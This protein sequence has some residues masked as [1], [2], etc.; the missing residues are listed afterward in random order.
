MKEQI[1]ESL[2]SPIHDQYDSRLEELVQKHTQQLDELFK[3]VDALKTAANQ[4]AKPELPNED[5]NQLSEKEKEKNDF[6][7]ANEEPNINIMLDQ[8]LNKRFKKQDAT[9]QELKMALV[10]S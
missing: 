8:K 7:F 1:N 3:E 4:S 2:N 9:L 6:S 10:L 5:D